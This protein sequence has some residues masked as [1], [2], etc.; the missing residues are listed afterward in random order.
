[1]KKVVSPVKVV[2]TAN[3]DDVKD[4]TIQKVAS[5]IKNARNLNAFTGAGISVESG[6]PPFRGPG[7]IWNKYDPEILDIRFFLAHP[8]L[9]W[10]EIIKMFYEII[11][12]AKPNAAHYELAKWEHQNMLK[13][14]ITQNIDNLH[15]KAGSKHVI[16]FHGNTRDTVC[17][18]CQRKFPVKNLDF[19]KLPPKCPVCNG[20]LKP[21]FVFFGEPIPAEALEKSLHIARTADIMLIIGTSGVVVPASS[22]PFRAKSYGAKIIEINLYPSEYTT[23]ITDYFLQGKATEIMQKLSRALQ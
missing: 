6:I 10:K 11:D 2:A 7:G 1:M 4:E 23:Q 21:D 3:A 17:M 12:R 13:H 5:L 14:I 9:A 18:Q 16:E 15:Q 20:L 8:D 19:Q 22:I